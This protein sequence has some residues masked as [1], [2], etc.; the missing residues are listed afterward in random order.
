MKAAA[1]L[2]AI[3]YVELTYFVICDRPFS[4][5]AFILGLVLSGKRDRRTPSP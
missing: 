4:P 5:S 1:T 2:S 3:A